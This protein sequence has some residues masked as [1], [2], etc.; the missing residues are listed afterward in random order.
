MKINA[1]LAEANISSDEFT[2]RMTG[3]EMRLQQLA[4]ERDSLKEENKVSHLGEASNIEVSLVIENIFLL[5][6][7]EGSSL[8]QGS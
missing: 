1:K 3:L 6:F 2:Q 5:D 4:A 7:E 8:F